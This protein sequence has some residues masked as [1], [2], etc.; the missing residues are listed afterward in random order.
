M[1]DLVEYIV[2]QLVVNKEQ[3]TVTE[4][5]DNDATIIRVQVAE[6]DV[7]KVIGRNGRVAQ[8]IRAIVRSASSKT[9][10][11]FIVKID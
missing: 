3:V 6:S 4:E 11:K 9:S 5:K 7:G 10:D 1:K 8:A 2:K